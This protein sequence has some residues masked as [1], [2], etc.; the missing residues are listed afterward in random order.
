MLHENVFFLYFIFHIFSSLFLALILKL[1]FPKKYKGSIFRVFAL[2]I[3]LSGP[4]GFILAL[5][6][7]FFFLFKKETVP[8]IYEPVV[9]EYI[10][11]ITF[12]G[13]KLGESS[14]LNLNP[15]NVLYL[16]QFPHPAAINLLK[17]AVSTK[18]DEIRLLSFFTVNSI[19]K[20]L[21]ENIAVLKQAL[22]TTENDMERFNLLS[23]LAEM[24]WELI[25]LGVA[26][27]ELE[28]FYLNESLTYLKRALDIKEE[29]KLYFLLG[30]IYLRLKKYEKAKEFLLKAVELGFPSE[31]VISYLLETFYNLKDFSSIFKITKSFEKILVIDPRTASI[32]RIWI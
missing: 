26:D 20:N 22:E 11:Q 16:R 24:Y 2:I 23:S 6:L 21:F 10:P 25:Y 28:E 17:K 3:F 1:F 8:L 14:I 9:S 18:D 19:E 31:R 30:R 12:R 29:S 13:R 7:Y 27:K 32:L 15:K 5:I 4:A